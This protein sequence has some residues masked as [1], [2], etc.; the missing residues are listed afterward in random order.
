MRNLLMV[1]ILLGS[2]FSL[3]AQEMKPVNEQSVIKFSIKNFG[4][5]NTGYLSK[6]R[7]VIIFNEANPALS[8]IDVSVPLATINTDNEK[9]D[10]HLRSADFFDAAKF[11]EIRLA[12]TTITPN[13]K[14]GSYTF[15]GNLTIKSVTLPVNFDFTAM[16]VDGGFV[17]QGDFKI[18]RLDY[19]VGGESNTMGDDVNVSL[20]VTAK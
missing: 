16:P 6:P 2:F 8:S 9:R 7:G 5:S 3:K 19:K 15:R 13:G 20:K 4:L 12:S 11:P 17:F 18:N 10:R 1:I 14:K